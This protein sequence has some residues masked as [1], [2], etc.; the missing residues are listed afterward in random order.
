MSVNGFL[1][2][3]SDS[4]LKADSDILSDIGNKIPGVD[5]DFLSDIHNKIPKVDSEFLDTAFK[6]PF[7]E[8]INFFKDTSG[9][10]FQGLGDAVEWITKYFYVIMYFLIISKVP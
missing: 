5:S 9:L 2:D 10:F 8:V 3:I 1:S 4:I 7:T 6:T